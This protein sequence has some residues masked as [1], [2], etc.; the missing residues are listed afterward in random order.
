MSMGTCELQHGSNI[1]PGLCMHTCFR[2]QVAAPNRG[3]RRLQMPIP[4]DFSWEQNS[5][6]IYTHPLK[7]GSGGALQSPILSSLSKFCCHKVVGGCQMSSPICASRLCKENNSGVCRAIFLQRASQLSPT[8]P[9]S[10]P[11]SANE[12]SSRII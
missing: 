11:R 1:E 6:T 4:T 12:S 7:P 3:Q 8:P 9:A 10:A 5:R 2:L